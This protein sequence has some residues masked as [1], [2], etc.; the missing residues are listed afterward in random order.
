VI[1]FVVE[2]LTAKYTGVGLN[3][4]NPSARQPTEVAPSDATPTVYELQVTPRPWD[5]KARVTL[6]VLGI[7]YRDWEIGAETPRSDTM[8]LVTLDPITMQAGMLS[9]PRDL[10]VEIPGFTHNRINTAYMLGEAY[11]LPGGGPALAMKTVERVIGVPIDFYAVVDFHTFERMVDEIGGIDVEVKER[12]KISPIGRLSHWLRP[13]WRHLDGP[14]AL[15][16][17][18]LRKGAGGD[19]GR[20]ERQQQVIVA[21]RNRVVKLDMLPTLVSKA[22]LL[23]QELSTG[24]RT[25]MSLE[26]MISLAWLATKIPRENIRQ[27]VI[28]PPKMVGFYTRPDGAQVLRPVPDEIRVLRDRIFA[29]TSS[30]G[31]EINNLPLED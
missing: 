18:R 31:P 6:L 24:V 2:D 3:P 25:N 22:P 5:G 19:F 13:G 23:Y 21:I 4:F 15:A 14:D 8:M 11:K 27:G 16:Y 26:Q 12:I 29:E 7:D 1:F 9:I 17:A 30:F 20:A 10:W 28:G